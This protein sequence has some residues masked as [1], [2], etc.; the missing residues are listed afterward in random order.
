ML[1]AVNTWEKVTAIAQA[2]I[3]LLIRIE[4]RP[5]GGR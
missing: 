5:T 4:L 1:A 3:P 2:A